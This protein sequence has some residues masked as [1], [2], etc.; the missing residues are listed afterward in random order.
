MLKILMDK[1]IKSD[2]L[3]N[4]D[5]RGKLISLTGYMGLFINALLFIVKLIVGIMINSIAVIG[6]SFN[7]LSDTLTSL[8]AV[9]GSKISSKPA[10][11]DHPYGHGRG[12]YIA[13]LLVGIVILMVGVQLFK[14]SIKNIM[15][16]EK[17]NFNGVLLL[18]LVISVLFKVYMYLYNIKV[19]KM[20]DSPLNYGVAIDSRNDVIATSAVILS[21]VAGR[22][23]KVNI[24][25]FAGMA[26]SLMVMYS[27]YGIL[28]DMGNILIGKEVEGD[29]IN[30]VRSTLL[31]GKY[32]KG[33]HDIELH[34]YGKNKVYGTAHAEVPAN[35]DV[36]S[37]HEI[38]DSLEDQVYSDLGI[39]L[40]I[41]MDPNYCLE[42]D[43]FNQVK[44]RNR[45][46]QGE[47][48]N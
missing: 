25:G 38:I 1:Y 22:V 46:Y 34:E 45:N 17:L 23:F 5:N 31:K 48:G 36:Y 18:I 37:M 30:K 47:K 14:S 27:G 9:F 4:P 10:D 24:D 6:D 21:I 26:V 19:Y 8:I 44:C 2:D 33:V 11:E 7:N 20:I 15:N 43:Q 41:H 12:E 42:E 16:P 3:N 35:I 28:K 40:S 29:L 32:V 39:E 13:S